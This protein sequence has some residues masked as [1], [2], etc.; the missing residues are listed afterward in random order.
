MRDGVITLLR[1]AAM[2]YAGMVLVLAGC[3]RSMIYHPVRH[4]EATAVKLAALDGL[5]PW[6]DGS[7]ELI[8]WRP[9]F[10]PEAADAMLL[11]H[12]NAGFAA[13]RGYFVQGFAPHLAVYLFEYP[14][15]GSRAGAPS[16]NQFAA[17]GEA[18][19]R[20]LRAER[21]GRIYL[22][23]ESLGSGVAC[24][25]AGA[26]PEAVA[27]LF[28][29]TPFNSL[30]DVARSYYPY[31]PMRWL[32]RDRYESATHLKAYKGPMAVL[33]AGSDEVIPIRFGQRLFD[34]YEGPKRIWIQ[35]DR[36][37]N[38]LDYDAGSAWWGDVAG[39]LQGGGA[40]GIPNGTEP[41][42]YCNTAPLSEELTSRW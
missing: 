35:A 2:V 27:G 24:R 18:A 14:G 38:K 4:P 11:F 29:A 36:T 26:S 17:A 6:R 34:T 5:V 10:V 21:S 37:H 39:F 42:A 25:L 32:L 16:E 19:L 15:Y 41:G 28:L 23:G 9:A 12:G 7:G 22:G 20:Q 3:Q 13:Q 40:I 8:G 1:T 30:V 33:L 31:L